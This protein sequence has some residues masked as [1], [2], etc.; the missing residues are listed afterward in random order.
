MKWL[1][2]LAHWIVLFFLGVAAVVVTFVAWVVIL[3][4]GRHPRGLFDFVVGAGRSA[5]RVE[6]Y[7]VLLVTDCSPPFSLR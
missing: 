5:L 4:T 7:A 6:A 3:V 1:L 2:A